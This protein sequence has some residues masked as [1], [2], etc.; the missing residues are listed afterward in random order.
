ML[1]FAF[2]ILE[3]DML[4]N[5]SSEIQSGKATPKTLD[6][7]RAVCRLM[8]FFS[9]RRKMYSTEDRTANLVSF[10]SP[11]IVTQAKRVK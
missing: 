9:P 11:S 8:S 4:N 1:V 7:T 10:K 2:D 3:A 6:C 5:S